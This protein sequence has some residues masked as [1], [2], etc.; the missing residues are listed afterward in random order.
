L[1]PAAVEATKAAIAAAAALLLLHGAWLRRVGRPEAQRGLRDA[2]LAVL[3]MASLLGSWNFLRFHH[4]GFVHADVVPYYLG[5]KYFPELGYQRL[6]ECIAVAD[7]EAGLGARVAS[8]VLTDLETY[9]L[10]GTRAI[11][12]DPGRC[13]RGF[14]P[15][16]WSGFRADV[17]WFRGIF[18]PEEWEALQRDH[19]FNATP[20]WAAMGS[21]LAASPVSP[22]QVLT[23][24]SLDVALDLVSFGALAWGFGWRAAAVALVYWGTNRVAGFDWTGGAFL[25]HDWLAAMLVGLACLRRGFPLVAGCLF[26][27]ATCLRA[28]PVVL[29]LGPALA[30]LVDALRARPPAGAPPSL[31][32]ASLRGRFAALRL[33]PRRETLRLALGA[34]VAAA[35][36]LPASAA[37]VGAD[38]WREFAANLA[39][40]RSVPAANTMGLRTA[41]SWSRE[42]RLAVVLGT[43]PDAARAWKERRVAA[44]A[45]RRA[46]F[47]A[48]AAAWLALLAVSAAGQPTWVAAVLGTGA[49]PFV[50]DGTCYYSAFLAA[51]G[52]LWLRREAVG[53]A[54]CALAALEAAVAARLPEMDD[55]F[56]ATSVAVLAFVAFATW[57]VATGRSSCGARPARAAP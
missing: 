44:F 4:P 14:A 26:G 27:A 13:K 10:R 16:R 5:T 15:E 50:L 41:L 38:A 46:V 42:G 57:L 33:A 45:E 52:L 17:Q 19:G 11:L 9:E 6:Y 43:H 48:V 28:V 40:H 1:T 47:W 23:L 31:G 54:L 51:W 22:A 12:A 55:A 21:L 29:F 36:L 7:L 20:L 35:L 8:R 24:A 3:A 30:L 25:R 34:G 37:W 2:A 32:S 53:V 56:A 39:H 18:M 49:I